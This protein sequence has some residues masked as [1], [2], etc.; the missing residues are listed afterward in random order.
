M[1]PG[2]GVW[3]GVAQV[4]HLSPD[5]GEEGGEKLSPWAL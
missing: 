1:A 4:R 2:E 5:L 3:M